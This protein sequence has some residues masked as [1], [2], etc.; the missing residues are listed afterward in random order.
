MARVRR[1]P[2]IVLLGGVLLLGACSSTP[3]LLDGSDL[4]GVEETEQNR[5]AGGAPGWTWCADL[6]PNLYTDGSAVS[7]GL[8]FGDAGQAG[9]V[10][11]DRSDDGATADYYLEQMTAAADACATSEPVG[12][13]FAI[14]PLTGL[15]DDQLGWRTATDDGEHGEYVLVR[16]DEWR[17]LAV[18]ASSFEDT[19]PV[20]LHDLVDLAVAGAEQFPPARG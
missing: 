20:D 18:G 5:P 7:T 1:A 2:G 14:E 19:L 16:L 10:I 6:A 17:L 4:D 3:V 15:P 13:G 9:A 8:S 11:I 12:R